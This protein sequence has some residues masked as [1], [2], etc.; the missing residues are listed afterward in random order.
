MLPGLAPLHRGVTGATASRER[1]GTCSAVVAR[2]VEHAPVH[3]GLLGLPQGTAAAS[4]R[5]RIERLVAREV[6]HAPVRRGLLG[7]PQAS[8]EGVP[9]LRLA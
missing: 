3:R 6:E 2:E 5:R 8:I 7:L 1:A 4:A 9:P